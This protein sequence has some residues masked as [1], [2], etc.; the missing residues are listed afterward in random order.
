MSM[1][2]RTIKYLQTCGLF[3]PE[4]LMFI[5]CQGPEAANLVTQSVRPQP[6]TGGVRKAGLNK[7]GLQ[8]ELPPASTNQGGW[9]V[10]F[11]LLSHSSGGTSLSRGDT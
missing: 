3:S 2:I 1:M 9:T 5:I 6:L 11:H 10:G 8:P 4:V 7:P